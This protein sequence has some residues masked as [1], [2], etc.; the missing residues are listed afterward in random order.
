MA[1]GIRFAKKSKTCSL[2][3]IRPNRRG[4]RPTGA[5]SRFPWSFELISLK[6]HTHSPE[7]WLGSPECDA[8]RPN[9]LRFGYSSGFEGL[10]STIDHPFDRMGAT[11][12]RM[13]ASFGRIGPDT[14][15]WVSFKYLKAFE[16]YGARM[17]ASKSVF[18]HRYACLIFDYGV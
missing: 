10:F 6:F 16:L 17:N 3:S 8:V 18:E 4:I 1:H 12:D 15:R 2:G 11:F 14:L 5:P 13:G 7:W 9:A